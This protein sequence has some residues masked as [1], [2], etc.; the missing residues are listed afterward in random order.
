MQRGL[1]N[2]TLTGYIEAKIKETVNEL[3]DQHVQ[4]YDRALKRKNSK[5]KNVSKAKKDM[6]LWI[7][8]MV[9]S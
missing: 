9:H 4:I 8:M 3:Q 1:K 6:K 5:K 7:V 2:I